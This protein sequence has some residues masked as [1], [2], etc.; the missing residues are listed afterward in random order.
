[1]PQ[2]CGKEGRGEMKKP[3]MLLVLKIQWE[4]G[5]VGQEEATP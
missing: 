5:A 3:A 1:M 4:V 2:A